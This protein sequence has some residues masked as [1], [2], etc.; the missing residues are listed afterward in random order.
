MGLSQIRFVVDDQ[1]LCDPRSLSSGRVEQRLESWVRRR[2]GHA[3]VSCFNDQVHLLSLNHELHLPKRSAHVP[4]RADLVRRAFA[5]K[6]KSEGRSPMNHV[7]GRS[8]N[9]KGGIEGRGGI[10]ELDRSKRDRRRSSKSADAEMLFGFRRLI[11]ELGCP[12]SMAPLKTAPFPGGKVPVTSPDISDLTLV[13]A[14]PLYA[15]VYIGP[16]L[17]AY[18][19]AAYAF[20]GNYD[21]YIKSIGESAIDLAP[22]RS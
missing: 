7:A 19:L 22:S 20:Y 14:L 18:P 1:P 13:R 21:K 12:D 17:V 5:A 8:G 3:S 4:F 2:E 16:W 11:S 6:E 10:L 9:T 15:R